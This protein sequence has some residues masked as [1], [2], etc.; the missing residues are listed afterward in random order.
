[1]QSDP[2]RFRPRDG[3]ISEQSPPTPASPEPHSAF[4]AS[5]GPAP[6]QHA[7]PRYAPPQYAPPQHAPPQAGAPRLTAPGYAPGHPAPLHR[8]S[9]GAFDGYDA[10]LIHPAAAQTSNHTPYGVPVYRAPGYGFVPQPSRGLSI[11]ALV[12]GACSVVFAWVFVVVPIIGLVFGFLALRR[13][14]AGKAMAIIGLAGSALGLVWVLLFYLL[15]L[16]A[17]LGAMLLAGTSP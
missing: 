6:Q 11:T 12:L 4:G 5:Y 2:D 8:A 17:F 7:A 14:P 3:A 15:P 10:P 1:M 9:A 16:G 13:E